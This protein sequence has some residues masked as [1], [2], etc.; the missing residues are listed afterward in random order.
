MQSPPG[1]IVNYN[2][3]DFHCLQLTLAMRSP[4]LAAHALDAWPRADVGGGRFRRAMYTASGWMA[5]VFGL[6]A[7]LGLVGCCL[8][9]DRFQFDPWVSEPQTALQTHCALPCTAA[10]CTTVVT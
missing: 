3:Y 1:T 9:I 5:A 2:L 8:R 6:L 7:L 10:G 4:W